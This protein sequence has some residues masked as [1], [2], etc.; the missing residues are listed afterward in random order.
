MNEWTKQGQGR[1]ATA[2]ARHNDG[3]DALARNETRKAAEYFAEALRIRET[4]VMPNH[5]LCIATLDILTNMVLRNGDKAAGKEM[6]LKLYDRQRERF[7]PNH[8]ETEA[9][10]QRLVTHLNEMG[11]SYGAERFSEELWRIRTASRASILEADFDRLLASL[12]LP[13]HVKA[14]MPTSILGAGTA[15]GEY[16]SRSEAARML[17]ETIDERVARSSMHKQ[18]VEAA[19]AAKNFLGDSQRPSSFD[20]EL[21]KLLDKSQRTPADVL[22]M[23]DSPPPLRKDDGTDPSSPRAAESP[24]HAPPS[25]PPSPS[26]PPPPSPSASPREDD[27]PPPP[28]PVEEEWDGL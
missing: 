18:D 13:E 8:H 21:A 20:P 7:G 17:R 10:L 22:L 12:P 11:D 1:L 4:V 26:P 19:E 16:S 24:D 2:R 5:P 14:R 25:A 6:L 15:A 23:T 28:P 3:L 27:I 9:T